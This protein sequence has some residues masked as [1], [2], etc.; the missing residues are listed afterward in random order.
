[1]HLNDYNLFGKNMIF[2]K[3]LLDLKKKVSGDC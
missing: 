1:M 3:N 2:P